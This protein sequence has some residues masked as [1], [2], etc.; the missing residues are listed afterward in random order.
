MLTVAGA[1][2][3]TSDK[4]FYAVSNGEDIAVLNYEFERIELF[5]DVFT[6]EYQINRLEFIQ[7]NEDT[8]HLLFGCLDEGRINIF[9]L[10]KYI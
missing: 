8:L 7:P 5:K 2:H 3:T 1:V 4:V 6:P 10:S 9:N